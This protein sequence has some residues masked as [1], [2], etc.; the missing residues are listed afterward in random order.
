M[1][2]RVLCSETMRAFYETSGILYQAKN[3]I[4]SALENS[5]IHRLEEQ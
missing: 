2:A 5:V 3:L 4:A 1:S